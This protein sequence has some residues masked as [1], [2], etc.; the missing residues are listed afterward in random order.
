MDIAPA[1]QFDERS[2]V[3]SGPDRAGSLSPT[4]GLRWVALLWVAS[5]HTGVGVIAK[6]YGSILLARGGAF[7]LPGVTLSVFGHIAGFGFVATSLFFVLAGYSVTVSNLDPRS[8]ALRRPAPEFWRSRLIRFLPL[9][10]ITQAVRIPQFL[11]TTHDRSPADL[12]ASIAVNLLGLQAFFPRYVRDLN[13]PSWTLGVL[14][15]CWALFPWYAPRIARLAPRTALAAMLG[16]LLVS[17]G[18]ASLFQSLHGTI[19][20]TLETADYWTSL[21]HTHPIVR[22]PEFLSGVL[23][24]QV[25]RGYAPWVAKHAPTLFVGALVALALACALDEVVIPYIFMHNGVMVPIGW[26]LLVGLAEY[27]AVRA[28]T[29]RPPIVSRLDRFCRYVVAWLGRPA[30]IRAGKASFSFYLLHAVPV[31]SLIVARNLIGGR[32]ALFRGPIHVVSPWE[33]LLPFAY[34]ATMTVV[35]VRFHEQFLVPLTRH[36]GRRFALKTV[37][38]AAWPENAQP[39]PIGTGR[40]AEAQT[41][42]VA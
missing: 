34:L 31:A 7:A 8:G 22:I 36:I 33:L 15:I 38:T 17:L 21:V 24:V 35:S 30:M 37:P 20:R 29:P 1:A 4:T 11:L 16:C 2:A 6:T 14:L 5:M 13:D 39:A 40:P 19:D 32:P 41:S 10:V 23:L 25:H 3:P 12:V 26:A 27:G 42:L 28:V 9:L 18:I